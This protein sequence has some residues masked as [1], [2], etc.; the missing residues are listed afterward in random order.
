M[1]IVL[2]KSEVP[3]SVRTAKYH[4]DTEELR[5]LG[6]LGA[7]QKAR[8]K[9]ARTHL[10]VDKKVVPEAAS[11]SYPYFSEEEVHDACAHAARNRAGWDDSFVP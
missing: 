7:S 5:R 6:R 1:A 3:E 10:A 2:R 4:C 11:S 9:Q 8:L